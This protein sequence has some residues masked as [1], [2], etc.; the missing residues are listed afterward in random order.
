MFIYYFS[1][2][3]VTINPI[4]LLAVMNGSSAVLNCSASGN[5]PPIVHWIFRGSNIINDTVKYII[6]N[7]V[8]TILNVELNDTGDYHCTASNVYR[9]VSGTIELKVQGNSTL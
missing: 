4:T 5:P 2:K 1:F 9:S 6:T 8:L 7:G 3:D